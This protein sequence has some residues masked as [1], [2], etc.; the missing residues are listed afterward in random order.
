MRRLKGEDNSFLAWESSVQ[1]QHTMKAVVLDPSQVSE[2]LT[3]DR[4]KSAVQGWVDHV[5]PMQWQLLSPRVGFG[6]PWWVARPQIDIE[7]HVQRTTAPAPGGDEELA[8]TIGEIF[9]VALDRDRPAWQLWYVEG[10]KDGRIALVLKIHHAVADGTASLRLLETLYSADPATPLPRPARTPLR[11]EQRPAPW[12][13]WPLVLRH[14][15]AALARFPS[16]ITRTAAVTG[17][18][19][20]RQKVGKPG[21]AEAF[22]APA[23]PFN[24]PFS[25]S[26]RFAYRRCDVTEIKRVSKAFG[27][28]I[29]DVFLT[30]CGG[31][32]RDY[33]A[34]SGRA[35]DESMTAVVPVSMR[36]DETEAEWGNKVARWNVDLATHIA[37]PVERLAAVASATRAAREVQAERDAWLQHDWMEYWPLFWLYSRVLPILGAKMKRRPMFSLIASNMRGPQRTLYWG[38]APIE[39]LISSGP[40]VFPM[41][42][43]FTGWSYRD[44]MAICVLTCGD[45]VSDP[46]GIADRV[47]QVLAELSAR[48]GSADGGRLDA[49][50]RQAVSG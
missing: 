43:N 39:Q 46:Y 12:V 49:T 23:M 38:G 26:R 16:I 35:T 3:F 44:E 48:A 21:Y 22:A 30:I 37:D 36:P 50:D 29:N 33:L 42:L 32:L 28:T 11:N 4:V 8:A 19:R 40:I 17:V 6:R 15:I 10:L 31:A 20:R 45:Q 18:I 34:E 13:W 24:E 5:E 25:A 41:G 7:H 1:P 9:E 2:P 14:Q 27:V 47:P